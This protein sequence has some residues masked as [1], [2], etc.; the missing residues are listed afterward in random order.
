MAREL[1]EA[2][3]ALISL[4]EPRPFTLRPTGGGP[5]VQYVPGRGGGLTANRLRALGV[6]LH[7]DTPPDRRLDVLKHGHVH[8]SWRTNGRMINVGVDV[9]DSRRCRSDRWLS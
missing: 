7:H 3:V 2:T 1:P 9:W 6:L 5:S 4:G 8:S